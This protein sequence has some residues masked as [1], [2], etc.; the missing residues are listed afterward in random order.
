MEKQFLVA[1]HSIC[2]CP[3]DKKCKYKIGMA[4]TF[5][6]IN[7]RTPKIALE[8]FWNSAKAYSK[9]CYEDLTLSVEVYAIQSL[10]VKKRPAATHTRKGIKINWQESIEPGSAINLA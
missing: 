4:S 9:R 10:I 3:K 8:K 7:A 6:I 1:F 5:H 2:G